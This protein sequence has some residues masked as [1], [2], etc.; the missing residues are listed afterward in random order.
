MADALGLSE[1][2]ISKWLRG[3]VS[4]TVAQFGQIAAFLDAQPEE[5]L[6]A[7]PAADRA[8]RYRRIAEVA[9]KMPDD[10]LE[11]WLAL[12][13]RLAEAPKAD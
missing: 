5:L 6:N 1:P 7:P 4:V 2:T 8:R 3:Q 13:R 12:G 9:Q 10:A 11:E